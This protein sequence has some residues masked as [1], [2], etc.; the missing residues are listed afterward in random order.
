[1]NVMVPGTL[2]FDLRLRFRLAAKLNFQFPFRLLSERQ[3]RLTTLNFYLGKGGVV[4][5]GAKACSLL[6][7]D[8]ERTGLRN[9]RSFFAWILDE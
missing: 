1:M 4:H 2:D 5:F 7:A 3:H 6:F 8:F 9:C